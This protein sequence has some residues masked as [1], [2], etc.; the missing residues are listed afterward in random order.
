MRRGL[1][2]GEELRSRQES[3]LPWTTGEDGKYQR[4]GE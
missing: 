3:C 4:A 1:E 2:A